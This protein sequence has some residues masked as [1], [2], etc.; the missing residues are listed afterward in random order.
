MAVAVGKRKSQQ[1]I[2]LIIAAA[3][4]SA[5]GHNFYIGNERV[6]LADHIPP[7]FIDIG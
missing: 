5:A 2:V 1:P 6:W 4:A 3:E 7:A